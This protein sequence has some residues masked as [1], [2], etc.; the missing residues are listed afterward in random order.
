MIKLSG[1]LKF[2]K[3]LK[4]FIFFHIQTFILSEK[5]QILIL[6]SLTSNVEK[7]LFPKHNCFLTISNLPNVLTKLYKNFWMITFKFLLQYDLKI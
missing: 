5:Q 3:L 6:R 2:N 7:K 1:Y 4:N